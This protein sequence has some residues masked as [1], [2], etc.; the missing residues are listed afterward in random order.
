MTNRGN[1]YSNVQEEK[2]E[3]ALLGEILVSNADEKYFITDDERMKNGFRR[4][5]EKKVRMDTVCIFR[6]RP[7]TLRSQDLRAD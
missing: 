6:R 4:N 3:P 2:E 7:I 5:S 1:I